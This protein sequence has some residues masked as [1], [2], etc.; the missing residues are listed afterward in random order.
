MGERVRTTFTCKKCDNPCHF[1]VISDIV[2]DTG[3]K[4]WEE[5]LKLVCPDCSNSFKYDYSEYIGDDYGKS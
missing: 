4:Q 1:V 2:L 3:I 5:K